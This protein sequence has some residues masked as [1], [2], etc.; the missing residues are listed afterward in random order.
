MSNKIQREARVKNLVLKNSRAFRRQ[1]FKYMIPNSLIDVITPELLRHLEPDEFS[2]DGF[3]PIWSTYFDT[4]DLQMYSSKMAGLMHRRKL[5]IRTYHPDP[6]DDEPVFL[7]VKEKNGSRIHKKR[8]PVT[9]GDIKKFL[10]EKKLENQDDPAYVAWRYALI[11]DNI[12][13]KFMNYY[14]RRAFESKRYPGLRITIDRDVSYA[15]TNSLDFQQPVRKVYWAHKY[16]VIEIKSDF[17]LPLFIVDIIRRHNLTT[18]PVSKYADGV[19]SN[20]FLNTT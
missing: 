16:S 4:Y 2:K 9:M 14:R 5:R 15:P 10:E 8:A 7:E 3:Y 19:V 20:F 12:K 11:K 18:I 1:E 6:E 13:P 17:Y